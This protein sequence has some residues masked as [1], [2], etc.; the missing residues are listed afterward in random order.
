MAATTLAQHAFNAVAPDMMKRVIAPLAKA[1]LSAIPKPSPTQPTAPADGKSESTAADVKPSDTKSGFGSSWNPWTQPGFNTFA[2]QNPVFQQPQPLPQQQ[3]FIPPQF[4]QGFHP[5]QQQQAFV[6][7][8]F[9]QGLHP[10]QQQQQ[11]F[12]PPQFQQGMHPQQQQQGFIPP[13]MQ[14]GFH[15]QAGQPGYPAS[16]PQPFAI[17][18]APGPNSRN[19]Y[20]L[21]ENCVFV[22]MAYLVSDNTGR[23][24]T[25]H[26]IVRMTERMQPADGSGKGMYIVEIQD[27]V[28]RVAQQMGVRGV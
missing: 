18:H 28:T 19:P 27:M 9:Q 25:L 11:G 7:P 14:P 16:A 23:Q 10:Q 2:H 1:P 20:A 21:D 8:Q 6:P 15:P 3:G 26:D 12:I 22:S 24:V 4:Q 17:Q 13:Q 5:A